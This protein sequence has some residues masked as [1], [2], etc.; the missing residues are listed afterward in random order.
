[1]ECFICIY[2]VCLKVKLQISLKKINNIEQK[3]CRQSA[4]L[5][6]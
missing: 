1:M 6:I 2:E 5:K 3:C 4:M